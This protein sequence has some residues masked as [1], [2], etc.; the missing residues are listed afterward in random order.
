[1]EFIACGDTKGLKS[2]IMAMGNNKV[3][4][5]GD[6]IEGTQIYRIVELD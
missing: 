2:R 1:M 4:L 5:W 6:N 3:K